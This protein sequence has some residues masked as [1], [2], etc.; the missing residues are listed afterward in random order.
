M[1]TE[2]ERKFLLNIEEFLEGIH[3]GVIVPNKIFTICQGY[4]NRDI[5]KTIRIRMQTCLE[6]LEMNSTLTIKGKS[7]E[8]GLIR[9]EWE[10]NIRNEDAIEMMNLCSGI[11]KKNRYVVGRFE[12]DI[13]EEEHN[14]PHIVE[15]E[16]SNTMETVELPC[17]VGQEVTGDP[18]YYNSNIVI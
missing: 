3:S 7:S 2:I 15:I 11:V 4:M 18:K 9:K 10:Y 1:A 6:T 13:F 17:W 8:D 5:D 12:V 16:L 14:V